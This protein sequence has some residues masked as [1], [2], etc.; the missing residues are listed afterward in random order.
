MKSFLPP[1][2]ELFNSQHEQFEENVNNQATSYRGLSFEALYTSD[3]DL[4]NLFNHSQVEGTFCDLGCGSGRAALFYGCLFPNRRA[5]GIELQKSRIDSGIAFA[6]THEIQN[7]ELI[8]A[9]LMDVKIPLADTYFLYFPTGPVLD[10]VLSELYQTNYSFK[11]LVIESHGDLFERLSLENW[12]KLSAELPLTSPRHY[13]MA[14]L[15]QKSPEP[16]NTSLLPFEISYRERFLVIQQNQEEWLGESMGLEWTHEDRF[17]L[18]TPPR[19][20]HWRDVKK[21]IR[22]EEIDSKYLKALHIRRLG[23]VKIQTLT[24]TTQGFIRKIII[25]P[26]FHLELSSGEKVEWEKILTISQDTQICYESL[27]P[28]L[29]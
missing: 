11:L 28:F 12:L 5:I 25:T 1:S 16:R 18:K 4:L 19:T 13:P 24:H 3:E 7:V 20:I 2:W 22:S 10:R 14:R 21:V 29:F 27:P 26:T 23:E 6:K 9:D 17:E 8:H 15:Y